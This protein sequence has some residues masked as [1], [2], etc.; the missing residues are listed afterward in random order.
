MVQRSEIG[1]DPGAAYHEIRGYERLAGTRAGR[2]ALRHRGND[3][4]LLTAGA[5]S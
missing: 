4:R 1:K 5:G 2:L 3:G